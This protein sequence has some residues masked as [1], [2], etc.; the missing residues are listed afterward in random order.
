MSEQNSFEER[1]Q[2]IQK[3]AIAKEQEIRDADRKQEQS[4]K[5]REDEIRAAQRAL[6]DCVI[7]TTV[8][9]FVRSLKYATGPR[10]EERDT[11]Q[12]SK[13]VVCSGGRFPPAIGS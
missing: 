7:E 3:L 5:V 13:A 9:R 10:F 11:L 4:H 8:S 6:V 2:T 1:I 12:L